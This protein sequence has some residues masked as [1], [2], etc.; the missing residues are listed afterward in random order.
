MK[1][2][3]AH[4]YL[5]VFTQE[6]DGGYS[7]SVPALPGC[8][9]QGDTFEEAQ[10]NIRTAIRLYLKDDTETTKYLRSPRQEVVTSVTV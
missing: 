10:K 4:S 8:F 7:A 6:E 5:A 3:R 9:S 1:K 2:A